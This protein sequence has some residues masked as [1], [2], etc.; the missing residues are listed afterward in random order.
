MLELPIFHVDAFTC[1]P[2]SGNPA[3]VVPLQ[4]WPEDAVMQAIARQNNL[5]ETAF[6]VPEEG[7]FG[8]RWFTPTVEVQL[9]GHAT[10][11]AAW[12]I[13]ETLEPA[14]SMLSFATRSGALQVERDSAGLLSLHFPRWDLTSVAAVPTALT[15]GLAVEPHEVLTVA[16]KDN[17]FVVLESEAEVRDI[18]PD[19]GAL[20]SLHPAGVVVTAPGERS[21][22]V[23]R[24]FAP[25]YGVP[26]DPGTGSIHCGLVPYW[27]ERLGKEAIHSRQLSA[28]GAEFFCALRGQRTVIAGRASRYL[29]GSIW[30]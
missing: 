26:E 4:R 11:A 5:S 15:A 10:L 3:A 21:D 19:L 23:C 12:V 22:C 7:G 8:L 17:W 18:V 13:F 28:R 27:S 16:S 24:Y 14:G 9:C 30:V 1:G 2:F 29:Q 6:F 25:S 20:A